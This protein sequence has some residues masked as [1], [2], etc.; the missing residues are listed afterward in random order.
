MGNLTINLPYFDNPITKECF[1]WCKEQHLI[2]ESNLNIDGL[3]IAIFALLVLFAYY[4]YNTFESH[5]PDGKEK[6]ITK[7]I[8]S[9]LPE[10]AMYLLTGFFIWFIWFS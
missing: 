8:V 4:L 3:S 7:F 1:N 6:E 5:I 2:Y 9:K 10:F